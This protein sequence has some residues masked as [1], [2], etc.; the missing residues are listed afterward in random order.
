MRKSIANLTLLQLRL[1]IEHFPVEC[2]EEAHNFSIWWRRLMRMGSR[3]LWIVL[4]EWVLAEWQG[5]M[6]H[7]GWGR[8]TNRVDFTIIMAAMEDQLAMKIQLPWTIVRNN[9]G[10]YSFK[11]YYQS[12]STITSMEYIL[13]M[14]SNGHKYSE[15]MRNKCSGKMV[16]QVS[17][18]THKGKSSKEK[19]FSTIR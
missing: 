14:P 8:S 4:Q 5:N 9:L 1:L 17:L 13:I 11:K 3:S 16:K 15:S 7:W 10:I 18:F 6:N 2:L 19:S 12:L